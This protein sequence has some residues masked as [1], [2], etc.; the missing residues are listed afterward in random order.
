MSNPNLFD[1]SPEFREM[2]SVWGD[3]MDARETGND[4]TKQ[5]EK[6]AR[7]ATE[8]SM[9]VPPELRV[10]W[11][12]LMVKGSLFMAGEVRQHAKSL[13]PEDFDE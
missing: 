9:R 7:L 3:A 10:S 11:L 8:R 13:K 12:A 2:I 1:T 6:V 4:D 5:R